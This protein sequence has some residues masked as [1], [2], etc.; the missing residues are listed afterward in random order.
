MPEGTGRDAIRAEIRQTLRVAG[1][2]VLDVPVEDCPDL[3][4]V[5]FR[6]RLY[7]LAVLPRSGA[8]SPALTSLM[9]RWPVHTIWNA[10][11]ALHVLAGLS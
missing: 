3:L 1:A 2:Y 10:H 6:R 4:L 5:C 9:T 8:R 7:L 11:E